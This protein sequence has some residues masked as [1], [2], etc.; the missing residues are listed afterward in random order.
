VWALKKRCCLPTSEPVPRLLIKTPG[1]DAHDL[2][3]ATQIASFLARVFYSLPFTYVVRRARLLFGA[4]T[5]R[6]LVSIPIVVVTALA[7]LPLGV[8]F[9][10]LAGRVLLQLAMYRP[11]VGR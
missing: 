2:L 5:W 3:A 10:R 1:D 7:F 9:S 4:F 6:T 11:E 8:E